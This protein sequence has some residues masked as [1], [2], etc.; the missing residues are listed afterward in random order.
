MGWYDQFCYYALSFLTFLV[1]AAG[2]DGC[3][4]RQSRLLISILAGLY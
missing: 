2:L 1:L 3:R 4:A